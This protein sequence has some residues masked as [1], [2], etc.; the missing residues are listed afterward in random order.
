M[1]HVRLPRGLASAISA[2]L[3]PWFRTKAR[4]LPWRE[5][6][7]PYR[8]WISEAMLQQTRVDTVIPYF[9]RWMQAFPS[10]EALAEAEEEA[11]LKCWE[12][13]GYYARARNLHRAAGLIVERHQGRVPSDPDVLRALPGIGPYTQ[14]AIL[15]LAFQQSYAVCD[16]NVERVLTRLC[17]YDAD[18]RKPATKQQLQS[19]MTRLISGHPP[20]EFN[21]AFMELGATVCLPRN[22]KCGEC[23]LHRVCRACKR[24][25]QDALPVKS[26]KKPVPTIAVGA[27]ITWREDGRFLIA[28][29]KSD[30]MLGGLWEFPGGK[31]EKGESVTDCII[32]ELK[33]E[34][35]IGV[36]VGEHAVRVLHTYS[37]FKLEMEVYHC[38]WRSGEPAALDCA[39]FRWVRR[40]ECDD[41]P[42]SKAD[43]KVL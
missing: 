33:E 2:D 24:G 40:A 13:L 17:A 12:G 4:V 9:E 42:F 23:P 20:G 35:G 27:A 3:L 28:K 25:L 43:L 26:R 32:R 10:V 41:L 21:E 8:V 15:S 16:G 19:M 30:Q 36:E 7:T 14:A 18:I 29:R 11:V 34:L 37:H 22:P 1:S 31:V 6:R 38:T 5:K 39:G